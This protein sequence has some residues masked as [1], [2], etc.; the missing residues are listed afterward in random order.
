M[1][2]KWTLV[3]AL[4]AICAFSTAAWAQ[5]QDTET[6]ET[7][8]TRTETTETTTETET[9]TY[10]TETIVTDE[11]CVTVK[12]VRIGTKKVELEIPVFESYEIET[13]VGY[14]GVDDFFFVREANPNVR[15]G[16]WQVEMKAAWMTYKAGSR[17]DDDITMTPSVKYGIIDQLNAELEVLPIN[18]GDGGHISNFG[19][20]RDGTGDLNLKLFWQVVTEKD[21]VPAIALWS[22]TRIPSGSHSEKMDQTVHL[23]LTKTVHQ[24]VRI[25]ATGFLRSANGGRGD[26]NRDRGDDIDGPFDPP[27]IGD[28]RH[29]Q[30]GLGG[31]VD[32]K[33][34]EK[35]LLVGN[36][37]NQSSNYYGNSNTH[38]LGV[39]WVHHINECQQ[40]MVGVD[41]ADSH[42]AY[43]LPRWL[44][45]VQYSISF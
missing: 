21:W 34:D 19:N 3:A 31:G 2:R 22:E 1:H 13:P 14:R 38:L 20:T 28:R 17:R 10:E 8:E 6:T 30:W 33:L 24:C 35:N 41:Y 23:N 27:D 43:E 25:H 12:G 16:Q 32:V 40:L 42:G 11:E 29:V 7:T 37:M 36:F 26:F 15:K 45:K 44:G 4:A 9:T 18:F 5:E 39:G